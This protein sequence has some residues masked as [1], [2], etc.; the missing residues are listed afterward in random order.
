MVGNKATSPPRTSSPMTINHQDSTLAAIPK[1]VRLE[2]TRFKGENPSSWVYK[3]HQFLQLYN[4]PPNQKI[5]LAAYHM[6]DEALVWFQDAEESGQ[7]T[8]WEA[9]VRALH[10]RFGALTND[11]L[12]ETL[13]RLRQVSLVAIYKGQFEALSN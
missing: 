9:F 7:F 1:V 6:E 5:L 12:M 8:S 10:V 13:T 2:F 4:T 11:D 3:V